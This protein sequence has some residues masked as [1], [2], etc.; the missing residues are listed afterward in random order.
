VRLYALTGLSD[1]A[2]LLTKSQIVD[3]IVS[4]RDD[5]ADLPPS[6]PPGQGDG[7][8][9]D[10]YS[11][12]DGNVAGG[13]ETDASRSGRPPAYPGLRRRSTLGEETKSRSTFLKGRSMSMGHLVSHHPDQSEL[14]AKQRGGRR[15]LGVGNE[16]I[17][18][19]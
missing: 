6:S 14:V 10:Y 17:S 16:N 12:D 4:A 2:E 11:S 18:S 3:A 15:L 13:E 19:R 8:S 1:D 9:S 7:N 5:L